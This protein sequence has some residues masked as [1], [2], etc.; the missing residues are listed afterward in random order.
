METLN[1]VGFQILT[2]DELIAVD[3]GGNL[4]DAGEFV[5]YWAARIYYEAKNVLEEAKDALEEARE[6]AKEHN[7]PSAN[8]I[9]SRRWAYSQMRD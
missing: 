1:T 4:S 8:E 9:D 6:Y 3:G 5:G 2:N 7:L